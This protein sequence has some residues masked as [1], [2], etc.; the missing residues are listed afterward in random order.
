MQLNSQNAGLVVI[1][2]G[3]LISGDRVAAHPR[4]LDAAHCGLLSVF[5]GEAVDRSRP[6]HLI[7]VQRVPEGVL[8]VGDDLAYA[9]DMP[10]ADRVRWT[11]HIGGVTH[12]RA[13]TLTLE[14]TVEQQLD[15]IVDQLN[16][17]DSLAGRLIWVP[18]VQADQ[19]IFIEVN[20]KPFRVRELSPGTSGGDA[21]IEI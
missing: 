4:T 16:R 3:G 9:L 17:G 13:D 14:V 15:E 21:V 12:L 1:P 5:P 6:V 2:S 10:P 7:P 19:T 18:A 20:G 8:A 11:L